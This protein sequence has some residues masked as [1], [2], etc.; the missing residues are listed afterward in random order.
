MKSEEGMALHSTNRDEGYC[1]DTFI[2]Q[3][4]SCNRLSILDMAVAINEANN[5]L[6]KARVVVK[7]SNPV[8]LD[9]LAKEKGY[10]IFK[11]KYPA[12]YIHDSS[13]ILTAM[14]MH[15]SNKAPCTLY[16]IQ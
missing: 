2:L 4:D 10:T 1:I 9:F 6:K 13:K 12:R 3:E 8:N 14:T 15:I 7:R 16:T 11:A 5:I